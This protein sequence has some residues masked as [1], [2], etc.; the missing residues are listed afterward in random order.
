MPTTTARPPRTCPTTVEQAARKRLARSGYPSL[1]SIECSVEE[2]TITLRGRVG[3]YYHKQLAQEALRTLDH[4]QRVVNK[5][6]VAERSLV[7]AAR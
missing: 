7:S 3:S 4:V 6:E 2:D 1:N 5:I